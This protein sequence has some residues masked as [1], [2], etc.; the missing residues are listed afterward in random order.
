MDKALIHTLLTYLS[1]TELKVPL[2]H[3]LSNIDHYLASAKSLS[4]SE[5]D[6]ESELMTNADIIQ[7]FIL[8]HLAHEQPSIQLQH[9]AHKQGTTNIDKHYC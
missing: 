9:V 4:K 6:S 2:L 3:S 5:S 1:N 8:A 7:S